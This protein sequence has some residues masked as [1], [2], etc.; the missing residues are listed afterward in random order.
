[1]P[2]DQSHDTR[3]TDPLARAV[4]AVNL[5]VAYRAVS[6]TPAGVIFQDNFDS[7]PDWTSTMHSTAQAQ[8]IYKG[9]ILPDGWTGIYQTTDW[10]PET[11][12]PDKHATLEILAANTDKARGGTGKSAVMW[13]ES[14]AQDWD[15]DSDLIKVFDQDYEEIYIEFQI[16]FS[17]NWICRDPDPVR[18][19]SKMMRI[20][21]WDRVGDLYSGIADNAVGP[22]FIWRNDHAGIYGTRNFHAFRQGAPGYAYYPTGE[23]AWS[24]S[25]DRNWTDGL[26]GQGP[27]GAD[28]TLPDALDGTPLAQKTGQTISHE[29]VWGLADTWT[30]VAFWVKMNS[31]PGVAD[32]QM[33]QWINGHRVRTV[34]A[35]PWVIDG[36]M[37]G[38]NAVGIGGNDNFIEA[39]PE[40][41][42]DWYAI[43]DLVVSN[44]LP[45]GLE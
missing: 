39:T 40:M 21:H 11:G 43:D 42:E 24:E 17:D 26:K 38:W 44:A 16:R 20:F 19:L 41:F 27:G 1:M 2:N 37:V 22:M 15:S 35:Y 14:T 3:T 30:K 8:D 12:Y 23:W 31:A 9:D 28:S 33:R 7:Q 6:Q 36:P 5:S 10:S 18:V 34:S 13:R 32:G 25:N 45:E 29:Q 4:Q